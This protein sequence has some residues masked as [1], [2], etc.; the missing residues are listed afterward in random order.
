MLTAGGESGLEILSGRP[1]MRDALLAVGKD[2]T[3]SDTVGVFVG[4]EWGGAVA[5]LKG[6]WRCMPAHGGYHR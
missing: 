6:P 2:L 1:A 3:R 4:G 5:G